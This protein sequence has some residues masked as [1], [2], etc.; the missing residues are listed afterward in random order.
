MVAFFIQ[1]V[2]YQEGNVNKQSLYCSKNKI[3]YLGINLSKVK[4]L[5]V[6]N[7]KTLIKETEDDSKKWK[8]IPCSYTGRTNTVKM[9]ILTRTFLYYWWEINTHTHTHTHTHTN[10]TQP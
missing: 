1:T 3:K 5:H 9:V 7:Y 6:E 2:K 10:V 4:D 8:D